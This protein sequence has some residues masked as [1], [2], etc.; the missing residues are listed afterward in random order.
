MVDLSR[1][2]N[3]QQRTDA[4]R[5]PAGVDA[6]YAPT[7]ACVCIRR[8]HIMS[9]EFTASSPVETCSPVCY[10]AKAIKAWHRQGRNTTKQGTA[11]IDRSRPERP[12]TSA[13]HR[14]STGLHRKIHP[15]FKSHNALTFVV[16]PCIDLKVTIRNSPFRRHQGVRD[17][18]ACHCREDQ[19]VMR[20]NGSPDD[21]TDR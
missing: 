17:A 12:S 10:S 7:R 18:Q 4:C 8:T 9:T 2:N 1:T 5:R 14:S 16:L 15:H 6:A 11:T 20:S 21:A 13:N 3:G 19:I